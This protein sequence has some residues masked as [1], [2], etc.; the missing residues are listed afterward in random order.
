MFSQRVVADDSLR[1]TPDGFTVEIRL[2][3]Y[4]ALPL[5]SFVVLDVCLD[6]VDIPAEHLAVEINGRTR[7]IEEMGSLID[8]YWYVLDPAVVRVSGHPIDPGEHVVTVRV[9]QRTPYII[10]G[11]TID[12][13]YVVIDECAKTL[14]AK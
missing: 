14:I 1:R 3:W 8:E 10:I 13:A 5:S 6:G 11:P 9:G 4:R 7:T 12:D 2:N